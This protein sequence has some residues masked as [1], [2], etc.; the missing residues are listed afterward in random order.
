MIGRR[1]KLFV[2]L[3]AVVALMGA[4]AGT[5]V[6]STHRAVSRAACNTPGIGNKTIKIGVL[7]ELSGP[8]AATFADTLKGLN[9]RLAKL[10]ADDPTA[11][12]IQ[13]VVADDGATDSGNLAGAKRLVEQENVFLI[14]EVSSHSKGSGA[15]LHQKG[16]PVVGWAI[17]PVWGVFTNMFGYRNSF[18]PTPQGQQTSLAPAILKKLG[19]K[20]IAVLGFDNSASRL[21]V[22]NTVASIQKYGHGLKVAYQTIVPA[23]SKEFT[24]VAQKMKENKVDGI[25]TGMDFLQNDP[26]MK[27]V[28][29]AGFRDK[30]KVLLFPFGY[31]PRIPG[32]FP[33]IDGAYVGI[34]FKPYEANLPAHQAFKKFYAQVNGDSAVTSQIS[35]V[36]WLSAEAMLKGF[37]AVGHKA[38]PTRA[39]YIKALRNVKGFDAGG[40]IQPVDFKQAFGKPIL[41]LYYVQLQGKAWVPQFNDQPQ[42][43]TQLAK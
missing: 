21:F 42:C 3:F 13:V 32:A 6:G 4:L 7:A 28:I 40:L 24:A 38:C 2:A 12:D 18:A 41:C 9:A 43:G 23:G 8:Q 25:I 27:A 17:D 20:L 22:K 31:D 36:A 39:D 5:A 33:S 15:Y 37:T 26:M 35:M 14:F 29:Q 34:D 30:I 11:P 16:I 19:G 1:S 10:K